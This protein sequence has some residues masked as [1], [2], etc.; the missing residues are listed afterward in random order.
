MFTKSMQVISDSKNQK[1]NPGTWALLMLVL[2]AGSY[3]SYYARSFTDSLLLYLPTSLAFI[4]VHWFGLRILPL[5]F[6]NAFVTLFLW[7]APGPWERI[8]FLASRE[9]VIVFVSWILCKNLISN[10][11]GLSNTQ[12]FVKFVFGGIFIPDLINSESIPVSCFNSS[13][14]VGN[15]CW[16]SLIRAVLLPSM[17][18]PCRQR[19]LPLSAPLEGVWR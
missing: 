13:T 2:L 9:P 11:K 5:A 17:M 12:V 19:I 1:W 3:I 15:N 10:S 16:P 7:Q 6:I 4:M 8:L 14:S 18:F